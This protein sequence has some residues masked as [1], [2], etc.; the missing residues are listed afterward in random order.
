MSIQLA[1]SIFN[2]I[3]PLAPAASYAIGLPYLPSNQI[4]LKSVSSN[5]HFLKDDIIT[6]VMQQLPPEFVFSDSEMESMY[7][8][9]FDFHVNSLTENELKARINSL[10]GGDLDFKD[11]VVI[12][13]IIL[14]ARFTVGPNA[15]QINPR[16][17][18]IIPP[19][20]QWV[21]GDNNQGQQGYGNGKGFGPR[22]VTVVNKATQSS[23]SDKKNSPGSW[24]YNYAKIMKE[25]EGQ[26]GE[27]TVYVQVGDQ[28]YVL[29]NKY[30]ESSYELGD[31]LASQM[32]DSIRE[33]DT[34]ICDIAENLGFKADNIKKV[35]D[36]IFYNEHNLDRYPDEPVERKRFDPE[37]QQALAWKRLET[38]TYTQD[39]VT[40]IKH[41]CA[42]RHHEE[43]YGSG[44]NEAHNRAQSR[45]DGYPWD[46]QF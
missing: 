10:R 29:K 38:N 37:L 16:M 34:D 43:K 28:S 12:V 21:Y 22:S 25:L 24:D 19:H 14:I 4:L 42:E 39:D 35:K 41:E 2:G 17:N 13:F 26:S 20:L 33:C 36:H 27:S 30:R 11:I 32:Y 9:A 1:W 7:D 5:E 15:F 8:L 31:K 45:F 40:W 23:G 6:K 18:R 46:N 44:Y 3:A